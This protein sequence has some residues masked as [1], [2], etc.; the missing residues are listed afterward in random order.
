M[1]K[2]LTGRTRMR[3]AVHTQ[4]DIFNSLR[5]RASFRHGVRLR[6]LKGAT[7]RVQHSHR[8][9]GDISLQ[10]CQTVQAWCN[11]CRAQVSGG[12]IPPSTDKERGHCQST[13]THFSPTVSPQTTR[14]PASPDKTRSTLRSFHRCR[15]FVFV[16]E[17]RRDWPNKEYV[18]FHIV[19][20]R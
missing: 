2:L 4:D 13:V 5:K 17:S 16:R 1:D 11:T 18:S 9:R 6:L 14:H 12:Q 8:A 20:E 7:L 19:V 10:G 15:P 3:T